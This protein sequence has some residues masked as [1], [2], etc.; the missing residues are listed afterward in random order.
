MLQK[1]AFVLFL[2]TL[3]AQFA[4]PV[5]VLFESNGQSLKLGEIKLGELQ[6]VRVKESTTT[7]NLGNKGLLRMR[8]LHLEFCDGKLWV[9]LLD[10]K[11]ALNARE[12]AGADCL[13]IKKRRQSEG[14]G[15]YWL[16]PDGGSH[17]NA[18]LAYCDMTSYNGGWTM[19]YTT[20]EY[21][22]PKTEVKYNADFPY[23]SDGYRT[24]CNNIPFSE[25][26]F[27][28]RQTGK[29]VFF[30]RQTKTPITAAHNYGNAAGTY[31]LWDGVGTNNGYSY[32]LLICDHSFY[33]GFFVSGYTGSCYK[34]CNSWCGDKA[35]P[36][37]RT[38]ST[39]A[40]YKG[41]AFNTN[42]H[43]PN[44]LSNRLISVGVRR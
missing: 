29:K 38:A 4:G 18:F 40:A 14:D 36:Y 2:A 41:V 39:N 32:Q 13:D 35:S 21:A 19:C 10:Q 9:Q 37:F 30:K 3:K 33:S 42:G 8:E 15:L 23:E 1:F 20:D 5:N 28:D 43:Q 27:I 12:K 24:N 7:C 34:Q 11:V 22:K 31:G 26:M 25:I 16:D 6:E 44:I 17:S